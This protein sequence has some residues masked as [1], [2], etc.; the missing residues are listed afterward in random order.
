MKYDITKSISGINLVKEG[1]AYK[2]RV[3]YTIAGTA[4][5]NGNTLPVNEGITVEL[6]LPKELVEAAGGDADKQIAERFKNDE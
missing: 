5:H 3:N 2:A 1:E 4:V 6:P